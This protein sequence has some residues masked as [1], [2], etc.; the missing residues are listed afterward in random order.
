MFDL[1]LTISSHQVR[2]QEYNCKKQCG[3]VTFCEYRIG[4]A[5]LGTQTGSLKKRRRE[6]ALSRL[7]QGDTAV[8]SKPGH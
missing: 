6:M 5:V 8:G 3:P 1:L 7:E 4:Q 2:A